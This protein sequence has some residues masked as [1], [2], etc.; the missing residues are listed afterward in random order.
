MSTEEWVLAKRVAE[1]WDE[2][3]YKAMVVNK[4]VK[5]RSKEKDFRNNRSK[6]KRSGL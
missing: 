4:A 6:Y 3:E 5:E 2:D 1:G